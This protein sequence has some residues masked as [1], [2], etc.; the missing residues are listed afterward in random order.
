M[1]STRSTTLGVVLSL[2][3]L[4]PT[5]AGAAVQRAAKPDPEAELRRL[6]QEASQLNKDYRGQVQS[7]E[8][9]RVQAGKA[10]ANAKS[11]RAALAAAKMDI[12]RF[13]QTAYMGGALDD[14]N[15]LSFDGDADNVLSQAAT[16]SYLAS[17]RAAQL[18]RIQSLIKKAKVAEKSAE[19]KIVRLQKDIADLKKDRVRIEGL[20]AKYGFQTPSGSGGL[21]PRT[22]AMR[23]L[24]LQSFPMP[25]GYGCLRPGDP[26]DHGSGRACDFMM[27]TGGQF[28]TADAKARGDRLAQWAITNG[29]RL[30]V[31][32]IIWQQRYYD[33]RTGAGWKMM[34]NR[35]GNTAN[36]ID[37]VHISMF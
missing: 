10:T 1:R 15:L 35:G 3:L 23:N 5:M 19:E 37:H 8:E 34:S 33:V 28:P 36:H 6:T 4:I 22:V 29:P 18:N 20:L 17:Q 9:T 25:Y 21:T 16:M 32:Y 24:V 12:V 13:A 30:G 26:G 11:L 31:M 27:S 14:T 2:L 7:L